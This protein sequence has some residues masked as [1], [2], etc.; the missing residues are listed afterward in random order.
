LDQKTKDA[1][2]DWMTRSG[3]GDAPLPGDGRLHG[4]AQTD[5]LTGPKRKG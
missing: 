3:E 4:I 5:V 2:G 1:K